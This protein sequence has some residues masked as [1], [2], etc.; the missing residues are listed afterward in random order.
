VWKVVVTGLATDY[1]V[2]ATALSALTNN[3]QVAVVVPA[4]RAIADPAA[5]EVF[6][7][8]QALGGIVIGRHGDP[9]WQIQLESWLASA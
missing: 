2:A 8:I 6:D 4:C 7:K 5:E 1:C 9:H 3:L